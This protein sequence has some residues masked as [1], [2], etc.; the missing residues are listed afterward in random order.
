MAVDWSTGAVGMI[1]LSCDGTLAEAVAA[2]G[3][4]LRTIVPEGA[5]SSWYDY[6]R[7]QGIAYPDS[8]PVRMW[9]G[10]ADS[11]AVG[12]LGDTPATSATQT[13]TADPT[14]YAAEMIANPSAG[15]PYRLAYLAAPW[16]SPRGSSRPSCRSSRAVPSTSRT[17]T[18]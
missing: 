13:F 4:G 6:A 11:S 18:P 1:G 3:E 7:D 15:A 14:R 9:F 2:R 17:V 16:L 8:R 5:I 12:T 10:P